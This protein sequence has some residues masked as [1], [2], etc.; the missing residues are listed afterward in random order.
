MTA[1]TTDRLTLR[2]PVPADEAPVVAYYT[3]DY[4]AEHARRLTR[5]EAQHRFRD[6]VLA[7]WQ[8]RGYGRYIVSFTGADRP[9]GLVGPHFPG[10]YP[11]PEIAWH[12]FAPD[13]QGKGVAYEAAMASRAHA[14]AALGWTGAVSYILPSNARSQALARR[15]GAVAD[16]DAPWPASIGPHVAWRHPAPEA[17]P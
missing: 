14:F 16:P 7:H 12:I 5:D 6:V 2:A 11:E 15:M 17:R 13:L 4:R 8:T 9:L 10:D 1:L 3:S